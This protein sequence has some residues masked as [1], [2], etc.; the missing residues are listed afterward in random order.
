MKYLSALLPGILFFC[1]INSVSAQKKLAIV[2]SSTSACTGPSIIDSCY[3]GRL[4]AY[5]N[6]QVPDDTTID[7]GFASGG[8]NC[9]RGMPTGYVPPHPEANFQPDPI[10]NIT[11][12]IAS[13]PNVILVNY[14]TNDYD[15]LPVDSILFCLR[16]MRNTAIQA[17]IPCFVT[18][19]Q[20]RTSYPFITSVSK[21][22]LAELKDS[23]LLEF[24]SFAIDFYTGLINSDSSIRYDAGD[25]THMNDIGH[26]SLFERVLR[27]N[28]FLATLP[29]S[30]LQFNT[31]YKNNTNII[32]WAT[33]KETDVY[34]YEIQ[35]S[36]DGRSFSKIATVKANNNFGNNQY[37]Y[38]DDQPLK[39]WNYY[40][41]VIVDRDGKKHTSPVM[42]VHISSGK[43]E[44]VK[45]FANS[46]SQVIVAFQNNN[47]QNVQLQILN[48]MGMVI[49][50]ATRRIE[51]GTTTLYLN[52]AL[53]GNGIYHIKVTA[54]GESMVRSFIKN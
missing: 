16:T 41:I 18:T 52:T 32:S 7:N 29:A 37:Q 12:A 13:N 40:K 17:G 48:N 11:A 19:S 25:G 45:A 44:L 2:G 26:D 39:G 10:R 35:R 8:Y 51:A 31:I 47:T 33:A 43:L 4:R 46:S 3:V 38:T 9:Y 20:P 36:E 50:S 27:E 30:F 24:G 15:I 49:S 42:S 21:A 5:F 34:N 54:A 22:K 6:K 23:I 1:A 28:I 14:P 53:P